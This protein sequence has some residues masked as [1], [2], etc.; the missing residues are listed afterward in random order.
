M[1]FNQFKNRILTSKHRTWFECLSHYKQLDLFMNWINSEVRLKRMNQ[2]PS[3]RKFL[4]TSKK[5][6]KF[7]IPLN[8]SRNHKIDILLKINP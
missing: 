6:E 8:V 2:T 4:Y 1:N 5:M 7:Q 3:F